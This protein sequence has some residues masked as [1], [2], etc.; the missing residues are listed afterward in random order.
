MASDATTNLFQPPRP[1]IPP[2][3]LSRRRLLKTLRHNALEIWSAR[4]YEENAGR[5]QAFLPL[6]SD[7][8]HN[9]MAAVTSDFL[10]GKLN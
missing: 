6:K 8:G 1:A 9:Q 7:L 3:D 4:A 2:R 10:G 5:L